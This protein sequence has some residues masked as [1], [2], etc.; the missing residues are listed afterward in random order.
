MA[1]LSILGVWD[2]EFAKFADFGYKLSILDGC[3]TKR[4]AE[5]LKELRNGVRGT[6][7][8]P[9][10][11][12][13]VNY[14]SAW[15]ME[16]EIRHW[17]PDLVI[18]DEGHKIK[19]HNANASK[20][21]HK[22]G[23]LA[24]YRLLLTGTLV[25]NKALDVYSQY[26]FLNPAIFGP[27]FYTF[28]SRYFTMTGYGQHIPVLRKDK[29]PELTRLIHSIAYRVTKAECLDLPETT[30]VIH[31]ITLENK[32]VRVYQDIVTDCYAELVRG[33]VTVTNVLTKLMRLMQITGG[34]LKADGITKP[35]QVS[36]AKLDALI[37]IIDSVQEAGGKVVV[38]TRF[39][40]EIDA[41]SKMLNDSKIQHAVVMGEV[42]AEERS[43]E[44][45]A[46]QNN[47][48]V[49]VFIGQIQTTA[50][51][52]TLTAAS[53]MVFY[54][55]DFSMSNYE[56]AKARIHRVG[57]KNACTYIHLIAKSTIDEKVLKAL[58]E[59]SDLARTLIDD[60]KCGVNPFI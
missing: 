46:F 2:A 35:E 43:T 27:S 54:S 51:G 9:L 39:L 29:E 18:A 23:A 6:Q 16:A 56:Q 20:A 26:K 34:F 36:K 30:D 41:I 3:S 42:K 49:T 1:P 13:V 47:P 33:E 38:I 52:I 22:F 15:R 25:T 60:Y 45:D 53:T 40:P 8:T 21:M 32:A 50:M 59:K 4:K 14:E 5:Q 28:R 7:N 17:R 44:V 11:V 12:A 10:M 48:D 57:Q 58:R 24:Q 31:F 37:D 19:T 55:L